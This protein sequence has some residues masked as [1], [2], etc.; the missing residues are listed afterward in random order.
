MIVLGVDSVIADGQV[1]GDQ[2]NIVGLGLGSDNGIIVNATTLYAGIG[3]INN[4]QGTV[5][6]SGGVPNTLVQFMA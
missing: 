4:N 5:T 1:I 2:N 6:L 3:T